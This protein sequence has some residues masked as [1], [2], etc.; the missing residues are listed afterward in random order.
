MSSYPI[1]LAADTHAQF[2]QLGLQNKD[3][4][5][6]TWI[7]SSKNSHSKDLLPS[8]Q[9]LLD[10]HN[11][12]PQNV[13][14]WAIVRGPGSFTGVRIGLMTLRTLAYSTQKPCFGF[15]V[16]E[17]RSKSSHSPDSSN[18]LNIKD[19]LALSTQHYSLI[20]HPNLEEISPI[21]DKSQYSPS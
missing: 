3:G 5:I 13:D 2:F 4:H 15:S 10:N 8:I 16:N 17:V 18:P 21:Y 1:I 14:A 7:S 20:P 9:K 6:D 19:L 11:L 12:T